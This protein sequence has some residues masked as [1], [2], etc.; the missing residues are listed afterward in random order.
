MRI[1]PRRAA[2]SRTTKRALAVR[3]CY[4]GGRALNSGME[5]DMKTWRPVDTIADARKVAQK[6][7][8]A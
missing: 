2:L 8:R 6:Q 3:P 4:R 7:S 1:A 5:P